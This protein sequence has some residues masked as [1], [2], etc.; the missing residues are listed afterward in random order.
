MVLALRKKVNIRVRQ[1]LQKILIPVDSPQQQ[2]V[3]EQVEKLIL[4]EVNVKEME[5]VTDASGLLVKKIKANYKVLG[6]KLGALMKDAAAVIAQMTQDDIRTLESKGAF[7]LRIN[8][9]VVAISVEDVEI[10]SEDIPGWQVNSNGSLIVALDISISPQLRD[11]GI[12]RELV[13]RIQN[14]RKDK[15]FE[16]TDKIQVKLKNQPSIITAIESNLDY[17]CAEI[18]AS[19]FTWVETL[20]AAAA[21]EIEVEE[22]VKTIIEI[23]RI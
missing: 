11:E 9:N 12:A 5:F 6:K 18:L 14:L 10:S 20:A 17:I 13:N 16:V 15:G 8:E 3:I 1:P 19:S 21:D 4:S 7:D 22:G 2:K 23:E